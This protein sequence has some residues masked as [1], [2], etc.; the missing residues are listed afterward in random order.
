[1][2]DF[3]DQLR[4]GLSRREPPADFAARVMASAAR[5]PKR[6]ASWGHWR[7][8]AAAG[9]AA[10]FFVVGLSVD[11]E[12]RRQ[13]QGEAARDQ[14]LQAMQITS[15]KLAKIHQKVRGSN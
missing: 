4:R 15:S 6:S 11:L 14:L 8:W 10:S 13:Q 9:I 5:Q 2:T 3:E 7:P 12:H 1:M